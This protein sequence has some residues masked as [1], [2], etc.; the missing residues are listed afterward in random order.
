VSN[1]NLL[2]ILCL[3][4]LSLVSAFI[5]VLYVSPQYFDMVSEL[6]KT[7]IESAGFVFKKSVFL[8]YFLFLFVSG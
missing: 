5:F 1:T 3:S 7:S 8:I 2:V 6:H 4:F